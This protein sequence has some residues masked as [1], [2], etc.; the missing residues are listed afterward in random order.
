MSLL[1]RQNTKQDLRFAKNIL[2]SQR[3]NE[4][5]T[6]F[7]KMKSVTIKLD[8]DRQQKLKEI[9]ESTT[10]QIQQVQ[11]AGQTFE[12]EQR[13]LSATAL[14]LGLLNQAIDKAHSELA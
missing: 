13:K 5:F 8:S 10:G 14:A 7:T 6:K 1:L 3:S 4:L 12:V 9:S 11:V 2:N